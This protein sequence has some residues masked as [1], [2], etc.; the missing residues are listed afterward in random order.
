MRGM[1]LKPDDLRLIRKNFML[2]SMKPEYE[3]E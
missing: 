3:K 2:L 1:T